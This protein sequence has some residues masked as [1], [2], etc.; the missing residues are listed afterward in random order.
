MKR[1][2]VTAAATLVCVGAFAQ[3]KILFT[4]DSLHLAYYSTDAIQTPDPTLRGQPISTLNAPYPLM[5]DLYA[6]T[7]STTLS[8]ISSTSFSATPG[9]WNQAQFTVPSAPG[10]TVV[11]VI[12]QV[13][14]ASTAPLPILTSA[15]AGSGNP[16][17][18]AI[19][20]A[21]GTSLEFSF[22]LGGS[23]TYPPMYG[24]AGNWPVGTFDLGGGN[25]GAISSF[26]KP[27]PEP[28]SFALA[29]LGAAALMILRRRK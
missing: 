24:S 2:L 25:M 29:G 18:F 6:G 14:D 5:S 26:A 19:Y 20:K 7:S 11:F 22:T 4:T 23:V 21:W 3:G 16:G 1:L 15:D 10:G 17:N 9:K 12:A 28:A 8:L 27:V 13:R